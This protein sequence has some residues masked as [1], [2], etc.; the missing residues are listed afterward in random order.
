MPIDGAVIGLE[1]RASPVPKSGKGH[2]PSY[3]ELVEGQRERERA[4]LKAKQQ[5]Q[6]GRLEKEIARITCIDCE[7][8]QLRVE[9]AS[10][11]GL[12][13]KRLKQERD[14]L[15]AGRKLICMA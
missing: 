11:P 9:I 2:G 15:L 12:S 4:G 13:R 5:Q 7:V 6:I 14:A 1:S 3:A 8:E 10:T